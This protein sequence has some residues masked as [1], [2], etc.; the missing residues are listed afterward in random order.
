MGAKTIIQHFLKQQHFNFSTLKT[1][2][3]LKSKQTPSAIVIVLK[4]NQ[5][6]GNLKGHNIIRISQHIL[7]IS[8]FK[9][10]NNSTVIKQMHNFKNND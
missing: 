5:I 6:C 2:T 8:N 1:A 9:D 7:F 3:K 4:F 10:N